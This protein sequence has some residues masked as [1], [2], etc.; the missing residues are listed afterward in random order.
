MEHQLQAVLFDYGHT[1][2]D[3]TVPEDALFEV[4][5]V[6]RERLV[7]EAGTELPQAQELVER[8]ARQI[9]RAVDKSYQ[10]DR[11]I[12]LDILAL[13]EQALAGL[14]V[15]PRPETVRWVAEMEHRTLSNHL[16]VSE[17]TLS[18]L[19]VIRNA[20]LKVGVVSNA[21]LLPE[22]MREDWDNLGFGNVVDAS[23]ISC[24]LGVRKPHPDIFLAALQKLRVA[25]EQAVF[26][27]DR[28][29]DDVRGAHGVGMRAI[30]TTEFRQSIG[31]VQSADEV[32][33]FRNEAPELTVSSLHEI[34]PY[35]LS[36]A[37]A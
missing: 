13:F 11:L 4:Y 26:V 28:S 34:L 37:S 27:G 31:R 3:F 9:T 33:A 2:V 32:E 20:G 6:I 10:H 29:L 24:E 16:V 25:P 21:H 18:T 15:Q 7:T 36:L 1:L 19:S 5:D 12:E 23:V 8:V 30:L 35:V 14:G 22:L 17:S